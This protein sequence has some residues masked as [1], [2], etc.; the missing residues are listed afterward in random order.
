[1]P[2]IVWTLFTIMD[3]KWATWVWTNFP[4]SM[5]ENLVVQY[6]VE[7]TP[8]T[9]LKFQW[10]MWAEPDFSSAQAADNHWDYVA[11]YDYNDPSTIVKW[12]TWLPTTWTPDYKTLIINVE[13]L[14]YLNA[15]LTWTAWAVTVKVRWYNNS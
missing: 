10:A 7:T 4:C 13:W 11:A 12:D 5:F 6:S 8:T 15:S 14:D 1:M 9:T 3:A 2:R